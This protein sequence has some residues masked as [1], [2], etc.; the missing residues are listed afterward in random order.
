MS[1]SLSIYALENA[2]LETIIIFIN[3]WL[4]LSDVDDF[5]N[6]ESIFA[7]GLMY[8]FGVV[9]KEISNVTMVLLVL[10]NVKLY[11]CL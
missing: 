8:Y 11:C 6:F 1:I 10:V 9:C 2:G 3:V 5:N 4:F 7:I